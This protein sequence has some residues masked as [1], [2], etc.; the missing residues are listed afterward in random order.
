MVEPQP[1]EVCLVDPDGTQLECFGS[2]EEAVAAKATLQVTPKASATPTAS[3]SASASASAS[4][5]VAADGY[6]LADPT[7]AELACYPTKK[8]TTAAQK[9][10]TLDVTQQSFCVTDTGG[11]D[12]I[13][14]ALG[15]AERG[16]FG[17]RLGL[18]LA[19]REPLAHEHRLRRPG[20]IRRV[21]A[22]VRAGHARGGRRPARRDRGPADLG[23]S[24]A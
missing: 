10:V 16:C 6:C 9:G 24:T 13:R 21:R 17:E 11:T 7:G 23:R 20:S 18:R 5:S 2:R 12:A 1:T 4:P 3:T 15:V 22:A 14:V 19:V 8:A